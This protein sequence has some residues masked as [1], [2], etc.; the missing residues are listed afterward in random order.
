VKLFLNLY[1]WLQK[2]ARPPSAFS[3]ETLILLS[4]FSAYMAFLASPGVLKELLRNFG[5][6]FLILGVHW[7]TTA[8][9]QLRVGYKYPTNQGF[10]LSPWITGALVSHYIFDVLGDTGDFSRDALIYWPTISAAIAALPDFLGE[11]PDGGLTLKKAPLNKRQNLVVLFG[12]QLLLSSWFQFHFLVQD[13]LAQYPSLL[14]D[15]FRQSA[16]VEKVGGS[17]KLDKSRGAMILN[18]MEPTLRDRL[19]GKPWPQVERSLLKEERIKLIDTIQEQAM[20]QVTPLEEDGLW[21]V[22]SNVSERKGGYNL[23]LQADWQGPRSQSKPRS[24]TKSCQ[25]TQAFPRRSAATKPINA[26]Q[27]PSVTPISRFNCAPAKV[28]GVE[29]K[30]SRKDTFVQ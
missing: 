17:P 18:S 29:Q 21:Q 25:I 4:L 9:N 19:N 7:G 28:G 5:W 22:S 15:D 30:R 20:Q 26:K 3:W 16:F 8:A 13:W 23:G 14:A 1:E 11:T 10:P 12:T 24:I 2:N 27:A 6:I